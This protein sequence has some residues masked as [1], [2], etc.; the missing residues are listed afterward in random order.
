M[1]A[2]HLEALRKQRVIERA[3]EAKQRLVIKEAEEKGIRP[4]HHYHCH[5]H[6]QKR[7]RPASA[8][9]SMTDPKKS[10][11]SRSLTPASLGHDELLLAPDGVDAGGRSH[12][13]SKLEVEE[14]VSQGASKPASRLSNQHG[15]FEPPK[16]ASS[17]SK[18]ASLSP[19]KSRASASSHASQASSSRASSIKSRPCSS[20]Q[21]SVV[22]CCCS[23]GTSHC[24]ECLH[25]G[26]KSRPQSQ[27]TTCSAAERRA[28]EVRK[29]LNKQELVLRDSN[30]VMGPVSV[31]QEIK[32]R[33]KMQE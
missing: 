5:R 24:S 20:S 19:P 4:H 8:Q 29:D 12:C 10:R 30:L 3:V 21:H 32:I 14:S 9:G 28:N 31:E 2:Y 17:G 11:E 18:Q 23:Q 33:K 22:S 27:S 13:S 6:H 7:A 26:K 16:P 15:D 25:T 1:A